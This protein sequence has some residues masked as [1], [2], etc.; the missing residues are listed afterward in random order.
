MKKNSKIIKFFT[1]SNKAFTLI[2]ILLGFFIGGLILW[3][4]GFNPFRAYQIIINGIFSKPTYISYTIIRATPLILTGLSVAFAFRTGLFNIGAEGQFIIGSAAAALAG[5]Y[6][7]LPAILLIPVVIFIAI[8]FSGL[9]GAIAGLLKSKY[10]IHEVISTIMLNWIALYLQNYFTSIK[11]FAKPNSEATKYI[12]DNAK[13]TF[14]DNWKH[15]DQGIEWLKNHQLLKDI[16]RTPANF[17]IFI[18]ILCAILVW[19]ILNKTTL[20]YKLRAVGFN[21]EAARYG[22]INIEKY[23]IISMFISGSLAGLAGGLHVMGVSHNITILSAMEGYGF[24]GIAVALIGNNA[25][26]GT[27]WAGFLFGALKYGGTKIQPFMGAPSE[28]I[29]IMIGTI[30]FF[31]SMPNIIKISLNKIL[32]KNKKRGDNAQ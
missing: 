31:I 20:G 21:K 24:D 13:I 29:S 8:F 23:T 30:V 6:I 25:A 17:G 5:Y 1:E 4:S 26:F 7:N 11:G 12:Y 27:I 22:G 28:I 10:G 3:L 32:K 18:A 14:L 9:W 16:L 19:V 15:T 2:S